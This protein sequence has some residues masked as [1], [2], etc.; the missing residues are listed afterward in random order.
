M[1]EERREYVRINDRILLKYRPISP[2]EFTQR[3][4]EYEE[5][6]QQ[7][8]P[9]AFSHPQLTRAVDQ[10][11]RRLREKDKDLAQ[12]FSLL[13]KK[14][15]LLLARIEKE[16]IEKNYQNYPVNIS[17]AGLCLAL[18]EEFPPGQIL[19]LEIGLL[20]AMYFFRCF[21]E[22]VRGECDGDL[23]RLGI[24]FIWMTE[25]DR[26][27]LI[28]HIFERQVMTLRLKRQQRERP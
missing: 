26:E 27:R 13:N 23:S 25:E 6:L 20:P 28:E 1:S 11:L 19:E 4:K 2:E 15:D 12:V 14:L 22:V 18:N 8:W 17:A 5:G 7:P 10:A 21:G 3:I 9:W 16:E 24:K